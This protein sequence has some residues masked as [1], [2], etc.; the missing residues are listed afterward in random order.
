MR[1]AIIGDPNRKAKDQP[2]IDEVREACGEAVYAPITQV[3]FEIGHSKKEANVSFEGKNL[4]EFDYV[5]AIP[6]I[7]HS[8]LFYTAFWILNNKAAPIDAKKY[9]TTLNEELLLNVLESKGIRVRKHMTVTSNASLDRVD[10]SITYPAIVRPPKKRVI[11]TN[12]KTLK[13][14]VSLYKIGTPIMIETPIKSKK[15]I[16]VF[17]LGK[18]V[19]ASY[20]KSGKSRKTV[21]IDNKLKG[22]A[23]KVRDIIGCNYCSIKFILKKGNWV[24]DK[25]SLSPDFSKLQ[26]ITGVNVARH[27]ASFYAGKFRFERTWLH[28]KIEDIFRLGR[29]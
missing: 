23:L 17:V 24:L 25:V 4:A 27:I 6:T 8:E 9:L 28:E 18:E 7:T 11:V 20:E 22:I 29:G 12:K 16:W 26:K 5:I 14:V 10:E 3:R 15:I 1:C 2:I 19:I 21:S 13:D